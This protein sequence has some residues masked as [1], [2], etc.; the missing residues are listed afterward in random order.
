MMSFAYLAIFLTNV[1]NTVTFYGFRMTKIIDSGK[2][3]RQVWFLLSSHSML[4]H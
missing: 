4:T 1:Q 3:S 2:S